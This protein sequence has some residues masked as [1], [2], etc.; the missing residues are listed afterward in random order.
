MDVPPPVRCVTCRKVFTQGVW[1]R[2][3]GMLRGGSTSEAALN[4][5]RLSKYCCRRTFVGWPPSSGHLAP[6]PPPKN[7]PYS[8]R[9]DTLREQNAEQTP[10]WVR[11]E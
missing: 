5:L 1:E 8:F 3:W 6:L 7:L 2:Y 11:A 4:A 10:R 9:T